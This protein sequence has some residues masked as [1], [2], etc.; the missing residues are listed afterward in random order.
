MGR[1][2][3]RRVLR[4]AAVSCVLMSAD[5]MGVMLEPRPLVLGCGGEVDLA[6]TGKAS[7]QWRSGV[8][9][10]ECAGR[11]TRGCGRGAR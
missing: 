5:A 7:I 2:D 9:S 6:A 1:G 10:G 3:G 8:A 4:G 11:T